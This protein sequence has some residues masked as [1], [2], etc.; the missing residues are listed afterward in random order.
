MRAVGLVGFAQGHPAPAKSWAPINS[1][2]GKPHAHDAGAAIPIPGRSRSS[3]LRA[4][5]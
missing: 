1:G 4:A 2:G 5:H 3:L